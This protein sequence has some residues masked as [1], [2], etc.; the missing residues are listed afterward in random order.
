MIK[1]FANE[2]I[3]LHLIFLITKKHQSSLKI[4]NDLGWHGL[5]IGLLNDRNRKNKLNNKSIRS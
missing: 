2:P 4:V 3:A 1:L 5:A